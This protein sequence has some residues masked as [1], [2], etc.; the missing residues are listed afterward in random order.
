[1]TNNKRGPK[2]ISPIVRFLP[3][4]KILNNGCWEWKTGII[5]TEYAI[6]TI[7]HKRISAH[8]FI[9]EYFYNEINPNLSI[10]HL[11]KN[12]RCVNPLHLEQVTQQENCRRGN[13]G[14]I[15]GLQL[16]SKT[17]CPQGHP[18]SKE[19]TYT[20]PKNKRMCRICTKLHFQQFQQR[21]KLAIK[22]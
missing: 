21:K 12:R 1:M 17:H 16:K 14:K 9:Y 18:Y 8:R 5:K 19:N 6:F 11:C 7:N 10:D 13:G 3:K 15:R 22:S 4:I 20:T 2:P